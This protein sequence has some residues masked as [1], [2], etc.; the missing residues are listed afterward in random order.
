MVILFIVL[1]L[2]QKL[3]DIMRI[4]GKCKYAPIFPHYKANDSLCIHSALKAN[5]SCMKMCEGYLR[6]PPCR[7]KLKFQLIQ[8]NQQINPK[9]MIAIIPRSIWLATLLNTKQC[10]IWIFGFNQQSKFIGWVKT[11]MYLFLLS[12]Q[13][14]IIFLIVFARMI[15]LLFL[16]AKYQDVHWYV[17][18]WFIVRYA[19]RTIRLTES[20]C[21]QS[22]L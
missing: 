13:R 5:D 12:K 10:F 15:S 1:W 19:R 9:V 6:D 7:I 20:K 17:K 22:P 8:R 11:Y 4:N 14:N 16:T 18:Y 2:H 21:C 3:Q